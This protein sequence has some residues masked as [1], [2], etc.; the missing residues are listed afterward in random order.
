MIGKILIIGLF[1][2]LGITLSM[3]KGAF[4]IAGYNTM[5]Q[6]EKGKYD[7]VLL[8]KFM[9]KLM[10]IIAFCITLFVWSD[11]FVMKAL[12]NIGLALFWGSTLFAVIYANTGNRFNK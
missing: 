10:F 6:E 8:C 7:V 12:F 3:G 4:F 1:V 11:I 5:T 2:V 9:G